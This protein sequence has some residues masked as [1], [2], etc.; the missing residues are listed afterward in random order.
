MSKINNF[1]NNELDNFIEG[2]DI[3]LKANKIK[4]LKKNNPAIIDATIGMLFNEDNSLAVLPIVKKELSLL[5][6]EEIFRYSATQ[7]NVN[8]TNAIMKLLF[9]NRFNDIKT[10][11]I[12][13][14][15]LP[16]PGATSAI[17]GAINMF[18]NIN[19]V[20]IYPSPCWGIYRSIIETSSRK[21]IT[22]DFIKDNKFNLD[23]LL[24]V[25]DE[26]S[27]TNK[28]ITLLINDPCNNPTAFSVDNNDFNQLINELNKRKDITFTLLMDIA[29]YEFSNKDYYEKFYSLTRLNNNTLPII[30]FSASKSFTMY[31]MRLGA[32][33]F[34]YKDK[35]ELD[36][37]FNRAR[38]KAR[39]SWSN[40]NTSSL[41]IISHIVNDDTKYQEYKKEVNDLRLIINKRINLFDSLMKENHLTYLPY[42]GGYFISIKVNDSKSIINKLEQLG[43]YVIDFNGYIRIA[44]CSINLETIRKIPALLKQVLSK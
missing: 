10:N 26:V 44:I 13:Y 31:G 32:L 15:V 21:G 4:E 7:G 1:I 23:G 11:N 24:K 28:H 17:S 22:F 12:S 43:L 20:I 6:D 16:T 39:A 18:S 36:Y 41:N 2:E 34:L 3:L 19:D 35:E 8:F 40:V 27:K 5:K 33:V 30:C 42:H 29:Y 38:I 25:I 14:N 37:I 9:D